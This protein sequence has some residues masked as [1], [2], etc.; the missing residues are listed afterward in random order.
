MIKY[1]NTK[2]A[3]VLHVY[4]T[5]HWWY[6]EEKLKKLKAKFDLYITLCDEN[7]DISNEILKSFPNAKIDK[8]PNK[9]MDIGP[10]L[11]TLKKIRKKNYGYLIKLHTKNVHRKW[12]KKSEEQLFKRRNLLVDSLISSDDTIKKNI[13]TLIQSDYKMCGYQVLKQKRWYENKLQ[14]LEFVSCTMF[15]VDFKVII[16]ILTNEIID[17][18]YDKMPNGYVSGG[19]FTHLAERLLGQIIRDAGFRIKELKKPN[20]IKLPKEAI[21]IV[22]HSS[23]VTGAPFFAQD[24]ANYLV[25]QGHENVV[26]LDPNPSDC[27]V[28]N[29]K[30]THVFYYNAKNL[31]DILNKNKPKLIY[32][33]SLSPMIRDSAF[34][35]LANKTIYHFHETYESIMHDFREFWQEPDQGLFSLITNS[36]ATFFVAQIIRNKIQN[37]FS[38]SSEIERK[39]FVVPEFIH[40][41]RLMKIDENENRKKQNGRV[42]IGMCGTPIPRKNFKLF[43]ETS[44]ACPEY[45]FVWIGGHPKNELGGQIKT[46]APNLKFIDVLK[47]PHSIL[48]E[49]DYLFLTSKYDPCPIV[50]LESLYMNHKVIVCEKNI[51]YEHPAYDLENFLVIKNHKDDS[52]E[53]IRQF[54]EFDLNTSLQKTNKNKKYFE[55]NFVNPHIT[56]NKTIDYL[57]FFK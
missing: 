13:S 10:F 32:S 14:S 11:K 15:M 16:K 18:W 39:T 36:K 30:I 1:A 29:K 21:V 8:Y 57:S 47:N 20:I 35:H 43:I 4:Y 19:S 46:N 25:D 51:R 6:F 41:N 17:E 40:K 52:Q 12:Q 2:I 3:I 22:N 9:G 48:E 26:F 24:L 50:V 55:E 5:D 27:F 45:D 37:H 34:S 38:F 44:K 54:K 53:I 33:N 28:L 56:T 42:K 49:C 7:K 23:T 31:L